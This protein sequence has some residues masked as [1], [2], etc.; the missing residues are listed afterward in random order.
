MKN[1][2]FLAILLLVSMN[3]LIANHLPKPSFSQTTYKLDGNTED[4]VLAIKNLD[5]Q[6]VSYFQDF[7]NQ[8]EDGIEGYRALHD[9]ILENIQYVA[10][11]D[12][13]QLIKSPSRAFW[14]CE[15]DCK[16]Y[17]SIIAAFARCKGDRYEYEATSYSLMQPT[18]QHIYTTV[19]L[20]NK[21]IPIDPVY[22]IY[23]GVNSFGIV[24]MATQRDLARYNNKF[25]ERKPYWHRQIITQSDS[26]IA[27]FKNNGI[28][29]TIGLSVISGTIYWGVTSIYDNFF[30]KS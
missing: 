30:R 11:A 12:G 29:E 20:N 13:E 9:F 17:S 21:R 22:S 19:I 23:K 2:I 7:A 3:A 1:L 10:D 4:I 18:P 6:D 28:F 15:A 8:F 26:K 5:K 14:D 24:P 16:G 27:G 25:G